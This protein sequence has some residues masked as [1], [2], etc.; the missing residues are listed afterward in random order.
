METTRVRS[1][2][3]FDE[4]NLVQLSEKEKLYAEWKAGFRVVSDSP[5]KYGDVVDVTIDAQRK[6]VVLRSVEE[7]AAAD[8]ADW[9]VPVSGKFAVTGD[10]RVVAEGNDQTIL[11]VALGSIVVHSHGG[12]TFFGEER[13][14][15]PADLAAGWRLLRGK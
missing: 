6:T 9:V 2:F 10:F 7:A 15:V 1:G 11:V 14:Y 12:L 5:L 8:V 4:H 13:V 3:E